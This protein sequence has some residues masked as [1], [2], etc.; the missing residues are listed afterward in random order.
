MKPF[1]PTG[2]RTTSQELAAQLP[3]QPAPKDAR[4]EPETPLPAPPGIPRTRSGELLLELRSDIPP[5]PLQARL[6]KWGEIFVAKIDEKI[7]EVKTTAHRADEVSG[8]ASRD[9]ADQNA[10]IGRIVA[11][12]VEHGTKLETIQAENA[13]EIQITKNIATSV[14]QLTSK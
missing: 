9:N 7:S 10:T 6:D 2:P 12:Q 3:T 1:L 11:T 8:R 4:V 5:D 14:G 13:L